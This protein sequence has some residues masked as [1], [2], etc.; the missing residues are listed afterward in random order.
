[1]PAKSGR[2]LPDSFVDAA[3]VVPTLVVD[4]RYASANNFVGRRIAGYEA[5]VCLLT[6]QAASALAAVQRDLA[7][8]GRGLKVYDCYRPARAVADFAAWA[9][10]LDDQ[11]TKA[12]Y[13]PNVPKDQLFALGYIAERSGHSRGST[14]DVT[15]ID[16]ATGAELDMGTPYDLFDPR[17]W[18]SDTTVSAEAQANRR[19]LQEIMIAR[20]F[21]PLREEWWHFT[22]NEE[23]YPETYFDFPVR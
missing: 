8:S 22:L 23:P 14:L 11:R 13:Y 9:R 2:A 16:L 12:E 18:P 21:R 1:P 10:D 19:A 17:S 15:L 5:P 3:Q 20:G 4:M 7:A 6:R